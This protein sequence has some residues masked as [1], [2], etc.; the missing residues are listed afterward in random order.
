MPWHDKNS[1]RT[2]LRYKDSKCLHYYLYF[3]DQELG[4][5]YLRVP[6]W[7]P[8]RLQ[9]YCNG[10]N[11]LARELEKAGIGFTIIDNV[12]I[13]ISDTIKAQQIADSFP[14]D[15]LHRALDAFAER[16]C[17]VADKAPGS[18][19][20]SI[21][22]IEYATDVVF[23]SLGDLQPIYDSIVRTAVHTVKPDNV[24]SFLGKKLDGRTTAEIGT[25]LKF[26]KRIQ[27][28]RIKHHMGWASIKMYDKLGLVL[29]I[30]TTVNKV[31][32]LKHYRTVEH[33]DGTT[34]TKYAPMQ[35][36]IYSIPALRELL[37]SANMRY[38][39][40]ISSIDDPSDGERHIDRIADPIKSDDRSYR[41]FNL[42]S[43]AD[44]AMLVALLRG[45]G[46]ISGITN[47][48]I[49]MALP[50]KTSSQISH[51]LKRCRLHGLIKKCGKSYKYYLTKLGK[52]TIIAGLK[53]HHCVIVPTLA[54]QAPA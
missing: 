36:T 28:M 1:G 24:A 8:F 15:R 47:K 3:I 30:E 19:H 18:Y 4:L 16:Y 5:C 44:R 43:R 13:K 11:W 41:G 48:I 38:L 23:K 51:F 50:G 26:D 17:P 9:F 25:D 39:D 21:M 22:Q 45:E 53:I 32:E 31:S 27:A 49:R 12:F 46:N 10:H 14:V 37:L 35:K 6:T 54:A 34:E 7:A 2:S 40:F 42:C 33:R 52:R 20:W 29:R